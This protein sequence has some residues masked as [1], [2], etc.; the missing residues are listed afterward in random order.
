MSEPAAAN[1][2]ST[3]KSSARI[4]RSDPQ[5]RTSPGGRRFGTHPS[6]PSTAFSLKNVHDVVK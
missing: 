1:V 3:S 4:R 6:V 2:A 5:N